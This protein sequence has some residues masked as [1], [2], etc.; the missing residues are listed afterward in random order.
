MLIFIHIIEK[1]IIST[2]FCCGGYGFENAQD[3]ATAFEELKPQPNLY[4]SDIIYYMIWCEKS[5]KALESKGYEDWG[6]LKEW[7]KYRE[8]FK[9]IFCDLDGVL[10]ANT[11]EYLPP[12]IGESKPLLKNIAR[13][14]ELKKTQNIYI[15]ITSRESFSFRCF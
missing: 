8:N 15:C 13:L 1:T 14:Q 3:F 9:T 7:S 12:Y 11:N 2:T 10:V 5:F 6:T 4:I